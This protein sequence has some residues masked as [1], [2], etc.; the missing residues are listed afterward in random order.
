MSDAQPMTR[1]QYEAEWLAK[2]GPPPIRSKDGKMHQDPAA[3]P[4]QL[5]YKVAC[6]ADENWKRIFYADPA[7]FYGPY[8]QRPKSIF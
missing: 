1:A 2:A 7:D 8:A 6:G 4:E 5:A 3:T